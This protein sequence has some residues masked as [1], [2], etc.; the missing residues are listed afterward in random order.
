MLNNIMTMKTGLEVIQTGTIWKLGCGFLF[1]FH[2]N[3]FS[4]LHHFRDKARYW[5]KKWFFSDPLAFDAPVRGSSSEY[6]HPV[7]YGKTRM[8]WLSDGEKKT[9]MTCLAVWTDYRRVTDRR[10]DGRTDIL[11]RHSPRYAYA[12]RRNNVVQ[13]RPRFPNTIAISKFKSL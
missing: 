5:S 4:I 12:S 7:W 3:Y 2:S 13:I 8:V 9:L 10:T 11:P 1:A 6:C